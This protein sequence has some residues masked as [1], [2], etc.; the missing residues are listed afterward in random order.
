MLALIKS[1][2]AERRVIS[3]HYDPGLRQIEPHCLGESSTGNLLLRAYQTGGASA[4]GEHTH[5]K[6]FRLDRVGHLV[7]TDEVF[8][9]A[10]P[11]YNPD[12]K[13]MKGG[14]IARL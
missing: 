4:S 7:L 3:L 5:W 6:L 13:H 9:G 2:I 1:A 10:R 14:I 11:E 12:D 8:P